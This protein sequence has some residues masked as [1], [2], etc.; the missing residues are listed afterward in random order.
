MDLCKEDEP[1]ANAFEYKSVAEQNSIDLAWE[2][3]SRDGYQ[4][5][6]I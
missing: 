1:L 2:A 5:E 3:V 4:M 6:T